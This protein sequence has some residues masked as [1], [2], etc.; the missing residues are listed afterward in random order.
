MGKRVDYSARSVITPDPNISIAELGVPKKIAM[1]LT[2][3]ETVN[4]MNKL[5]LLKL[6]QNGPNVYPGAKI[7]ERE[8]GERIFLENVDRASLTIAEGDKVHRHMMDGDPVLFNRQPTLHRMSMMCHLARIMPVG[9]TFRMN[10]GDTKP[11]NAD[12]DGDEMNLHMP[13]DE[14]SRAELKQLAAVPWHIISPANNKSIVGIFQ[15]SLLGS[16]LMTRGGTEIPMREAMNLL[17]H[18]KKVDVTKLGRGTSVSSYRLLSQILP[19]FSLRYR[20]RQYV[21]GAKN[22]ELDGV[23]EIA[24]GVY[25]SGQLDK[26]ALGDGSKGLIHRICNDFGNAQSAEFIDDLQNIVTGY[27]RTSAYSV[28]ISDLM[29][30]EATN[31]EITEVISSKKREVQS[32]IDETHLGI[33]E[34]KS[35]RTND[36]EFETKVNSVLGQALSQAGR[37]GL[38]SLSKDNRFV[39]MVRAGSKG[40]DINISQMV[41]CLGQQQVD[42]KRIPYGFE[43]RTLP[44]YTKYDDS[45]VARGFVEQSFIDGLKPAE[46]FFHAM[47]GRV[48]LIDTAVKTSQTGY[49]QRRLVKSLEDLKVEYDMT[50][51]NGKNKVIQFRYG[52]DSFDT[53]AVEKQSIPLATMTMDEIY[54]HFHLPTASAAK[55]FI[56]TASALARAKSEEVALGTRVKALLEMT[57]LARAPL[58]NNV[59]A[60]RNETAVHSP[61]AF[62][63]IIANVAGQLGIGPDNACDITALELIT[64]VDKTYDTLMRTTFAPPTQLFKLLLYYYCSPTSQNCSR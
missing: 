48:G 26:G 27:M 14:E 28:G 61:V 1:N 8:N 63:Y 57:L 49:I 41:S 32:F 39:T 53:I 34:N 24:N 25:L 29:A 52:D 13:Q 51:R 42:G 17:M 55:D 50:V 54:A 60:A 36:V 40:S 7:L 58:V 59:F 44:H 23:L 6:V 15:D 11:Y 10:V 19:P 5:F 56:Y 3:P 18:Y 16:Y 20:T 31:T 46:L 64:A 37:I 62:R 30:N 33:F 47:G 35:G 21:E 12:F 38:T 9:D 45:P 43:E 2:Y 22:A 4:G